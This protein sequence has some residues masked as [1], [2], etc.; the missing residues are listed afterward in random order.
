MSPIRES[1]TGGSITYVKLVSSKFCVC[2]GDMYFLRT[3]LF[4]YILGA[5]QYTYLLMYIWFLFIDVN[6]YYV[7][8]FLLVCLLLTV[9]SNSICMVHSPKTNQIFI[10]S[11]LDRNNVNEKRNKWIQHSKRP[12]CRCPTVWVREFDWNNRKQGVVAACVRLSHLGGWQPWVNSEF[13]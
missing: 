10:H 7:L 9:V 13:N 3:V 11:S 12:F 4:K 2:I 8:F 6:L 5:N 1:R